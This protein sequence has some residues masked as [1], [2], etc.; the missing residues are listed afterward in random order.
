MHAPAVRKALR[1]L[2][3][4]TSTAPRRTSVDNGNGREQ[5]LSSSENSPSNHI[6]NVC[7]GIKSKSNAHVEWGRRTISAFG[8]AN[9][10]RQ[11]M[12]SGFESYCWSGFHHSYSA[13]PT[14]FLF[15]HLTVNIP[16]LRTPIL[17]HMTARLTTHSGTTHRGWSGSAPRTSSS[18]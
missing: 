18:S 7:D 9:L 11:P 12:E 15:Q 14:L 5:F 8:T 13:C 6:T 4:Q 3:C 1:G 10:A 16:L 2:S 17:R